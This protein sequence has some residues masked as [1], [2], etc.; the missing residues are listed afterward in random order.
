M[1]SDPKHLSRRHFMAGAAAAGVLAG[2]GLA[3]ADPAKARTFPGLPDGA[4]PYDW[5]LE[6]LRVAQAHQ[7]HRGAKEVVVA[8]I[9]LGYRHHP[10]LDGHLWENPNP[11]RGDRHG[12]DFADDDASLEYAGPDADS[13]YYRNHHVF[14]AG[15][16]AAV[17]PGCLV[18]PLRVGYRSHDLDR[19]DHG[20]VHRAVAATE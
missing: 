9:D 20:R 2:R 16:V 10:L 17:A 5:P 7:L 14:V 3:A 11:A 8:V 6:Q 4:R 18:M 1:A 19:H 13:A 12:W 15:E